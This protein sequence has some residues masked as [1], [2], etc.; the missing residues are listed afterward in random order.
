MESLDNF[1]CDGAVVYVDAHA[2]PHA[3]VEVL[4]DFGLYEELQFHIGVVLA[5]VFETRFHRCEY[6]ALV[7]HA[8]RR[9]EINESRYA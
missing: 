2:V 1:R 3:E 8:L 7:A 5:D 4:V 6:H 9:D